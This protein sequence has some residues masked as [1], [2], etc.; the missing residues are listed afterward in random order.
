MFSL[1]T[2]ARPIASRTASTAAVRGLSTQTT[3]A[4]EKLKSVLEGYRLA[5]YQQE[6]PMRFKKDIAKAAVVHDDLVGVDGVERVLYNI[7]AEQRL[8]KQELEGIFTEMGEG[9]EIPASRFLQ[10][11]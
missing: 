10:M 5:N 11:I 6:L 2:L 7:G 4:V 1:R 9:G 8:S 3:E